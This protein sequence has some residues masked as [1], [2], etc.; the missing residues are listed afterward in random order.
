MQLLREEYIEQAYLFRVL[1]E[2]LGMDISLQ[3]LLLQVKHELLAST[4][5]P[6]AVEFLLTELKH[7][8]IMAQG[9]R[10]LGH[11]FSSFQCFIIEQ[12]EKDA[13]RFDFKMALQI[14][15][16]ESQYL[17]EGGTRQGLFFYQFES[18]CRN[19]LQYDAGLKSIS[20]DPMYDAAWKE[21]IL[22]IRRQLGL[23]DLADLIYGRSEDFIAY[24]KRKLGPDATFDLPILFGEKEGKIAFANRRKDPLYLFAAL[25]RH[26]NYPIVPRLEKVEQHLESIPLMQRRIERLESRIRLMEEENREGIDITKFYGDKGPS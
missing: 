19:R 26:L 8:G 23:V 20:E 7:N 4:K 10:L 1:L 24:R 9:M 15:Q 17:A 11:Y 18:L 25:Q 14:L 22:V 6:M 12:A 21:W 13:G 16:K 5:L 2:R 3:E